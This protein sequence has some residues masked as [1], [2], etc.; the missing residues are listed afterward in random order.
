MHNSSKKP[1][2]EIKL[3]SYLK[4]EACI[5]KSSPTVENGGGY[6]IDTLGKKKSHSVGVYTGVT[7]KVARKR[8]VELSV[9][10]NWVYSSRTATS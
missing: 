7:L 4:N 2:L 9:V 8:R 1:N 6:S 3:Q 5:W 10:F